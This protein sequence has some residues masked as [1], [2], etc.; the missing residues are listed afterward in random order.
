MKTVIFS[1]VLFLSTGLLAQSQQS[2][3]PGSPSVS[4]VSQEDVAKIKNQVTALQEAFGI[5]HE[6]KPTEKNMAQVADKALDMVTKLTAQLDETLK[7]I[8]PD[9]WD[10]MVRQQYAKAIGEPV[11]A[12]ALVFIAMLM[13]KY[14]GSLKVDGDANIARNV[15][16][17]ASIIGAIISGIVFVYYFSDSIMILINPR[18]YAIK[19][20]LSL[21]LNKG[22]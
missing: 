17:G 2:Q 4:P 14:L 1:I 8:A 10:I 3:Q 7:K 18:Y 16:V 19:D 21:L 20:L 12:F 15:G 9:V 13:K 11:V 5:Q 6:Q 22:S